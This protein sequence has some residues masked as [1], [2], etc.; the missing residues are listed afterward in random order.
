MTLPHISTSEAQKLIA[1]G[2]VLVDIR[3]PDEHARERI[4]LAR[5]EPLSRLR[6]VSVPEATPAVI[7]HCKAGSRTAAN[8]ER[9]A[10]STQC[11]AYILDGGI[12]AWKSAG[13][14][15]IADRKQPIEMMRQVQI[16]AGSLVVTGAVLGT[17]VS[18]GFYALSAFVG[19]G[20]VFAGVSGTC[21]MARILALAPW[22]R[23]ATAALG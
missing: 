10:S 8:V 3:E 23:R 2:A 16:V 18:P 22:N 13:L 7:F 21:M 9:L 11:D 15:V 14:P 20:L 19:A 5:H 17:W 6:D 1:R 12:E 4:A